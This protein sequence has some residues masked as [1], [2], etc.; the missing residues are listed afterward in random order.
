MG[1]DEVPAGWRGMTSNLHQSGEFSILWAWRCSGRHV[2]GAEGK[3][4]L[5]MLCLITAS[6]IEATL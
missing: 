4:S 5:P 1:R 6:Q 2:A 3:G